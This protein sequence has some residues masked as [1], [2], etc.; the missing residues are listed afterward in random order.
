MHNK[1]IFYSM[2]S[3]L[4]YILNESKSHDLEYLLITMLKENI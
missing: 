4:K 3:K 1:H 2:H